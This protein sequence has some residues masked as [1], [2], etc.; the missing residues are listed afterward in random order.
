MQNIIDPAITYLDVVD[1]WGL[2][3]GD[4]VFLSS[5]ITDL[6]YLEIENGRGKPS[7]NL[8]IDK[9]IQTIGEDGTLI[10]PTYNW[11]FCKGITFDWKKTKGKTGILGNICLKRPDFKRT[12]HPIYSCVVY[13]KDQQLLCGL[14]YVSSFGSDSIFAYLEKNHAKHVIINVPLTQCFTY[15]HHI[16]ESFIPLKYRYLKE[17]TADYI[18]ED[19]QVSTRKAVML[20]RDLDLD[21]EG[22]PAMEQTFQDKGILRKIFINNIQFTL[23]DDVS[24][25]NDTLTDDI[26]NH[27]SSIICKYKGQMEKGQEMYKLAERLFP[28][29]RSITGNGFRESLNIIREEIPE[30]KVCEV[31]SG[32]QVFDW[33]VPKEWNINGGGIYTLDGQK[34]IDFKDNNLH[35]LGYSTPIDAIVSKEELLNHLYTM[36]DQPDWIPYVTSYYKERWGFCMS[37]KQKQTLNEKEYHVIIDS[38]LEEG[39]LTYGE[40]I[41]PGET[42]DEILITTYLCHPSMANNELSGPVVWQEIIKYVQKLKNRHYTYRFL[43]NPETI[44]SITYISQHLKALKDHVKAGF[45]LSCVGDERTYS[46]MESRMGNTLADKVAK[47]V[48]SYHY[49]AFQTYSFLSRGSDE[50]QYC[51]PKVDLPVCGICRSKYMEYPEYHTSADDMSLITPNGLVGSRDLMIKIINALEYN[52]CYET[53]CYCEPQLGKRGLYPTI[54]RKGAYDSILAL[55]DF[56]AYADGKMDLI[57]ISNKINQPIDVLIPIIIKLK[58]E[59]LISSTTPDA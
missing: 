24:L 30:I 27:N 43:I 31:P 10:L 58:N 52:L 59:G 46:Y 41:I 57:D 4:I 47:N 44:G 6:F 18:A 37:E 21:V 23:F 34:V 9:I 25:A 14:D 28:I 42:T 7:A 17:F 33:T 50:R 39:S 20:V 51:S 54:S 1:Y 2:K 12:K 48:L 53:Q 36:P 8:F 19:G 55:K 15:A 22:V 5:D 29:C 45:V 49:P 16:E 13:G 11:D 40:L 32:T 56:I 26:L 35:I 38:K 3:K